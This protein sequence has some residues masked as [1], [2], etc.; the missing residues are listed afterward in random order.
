MLTVCKRDADKK[1][2]CICK[3]YVT[4]VIINRYWWLF[5]YIWRA[6]RKK[7]FRKTFF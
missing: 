5:Y 4:D 7:Y 6:D 2:I 1:N 3:L